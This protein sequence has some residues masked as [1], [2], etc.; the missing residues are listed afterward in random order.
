MI[1]KEP[2][3]GAREPS[4]TQRLST[5]TAQEPAGAERTAQF[6]ESRYEIKLVAPRS[7]LPRVRALLRLHS[8]GFSVAYPT[9]RVNNVYF[10]TPEL[11]SVDANLAGISERWKLRLRWYGNTSVVVDGVW[12][13]KRKSGG[14]G[15]KVCQALDQ[16]L[17]LGQ[18]RRTEISQLLRSCVPSLMAPHLVPELSPTLFNHYQREYYESRDGAL[19]ATLDYDQFFYD[20]QH[21]MRL[22]V[23]RKA[24]FLDT[25]IL[26]LK[27]GVD[28]HDQL[29][30]AI[31][32]FPMRVSRNSKYVNGI[33]HSGLL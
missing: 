13:L 23:T 4:P 11:S 16:T 33:L 7:D 31:Q 28:C 18:L 21:S 6:G 24:P 25:T 17:D 1:L 3:R 29:S 26:E 22:N 30:D 20:Q 10:D 32:H 9:R 8:V 12:E 15:W 19:R 2:R 5:S 14:L 27:A